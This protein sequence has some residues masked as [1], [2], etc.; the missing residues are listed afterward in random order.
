MTIEIHP[1]IYVEGKN[2]L[3][4][5]VELLIRNG[6]PYVNPF[7]S[8]PIELPEFKP[9]DGDEGV[10]NSVKLS[11]EF[12]K[13]RTVGFVIDADLSQPSRWKAISSR[14]E[15]VG[16][17]VPEKIPSNGF[18]GYS[19][20]YQTKV[21]VW[22]MPDNQSSGALEDFLKKLIDDKDPLIEHAVNSTTEAKY[23]KARFSD[24]DIKKAE[25]HTW[26]A[27]QKDPGCKYGIAINAEYFQ[28]NSK[29]AKRFVNWFKKLYDIETE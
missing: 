28:H 20:E 8:S 2:D 26:L 17:E 16:V 11:I 18:I 10:L 12:S 23:L 29:L 21:G 5:L 15:N 1:K 6:I 22:L 9:C 4:A 27:W 25:L 14:L 24:S 13:G 3:F 7:K 19:D